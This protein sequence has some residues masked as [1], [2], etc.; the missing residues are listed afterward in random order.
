MDVKMENKK[1]GKCPCCE[2]YSIGFGE[3][4]L[5]DICPV[6]FWENGGDGPNHMTLEEARKNFN[7]IGAIDKKA[8]EFI[9]P[10]SKNKY[11]RKMLNKIKVFSF[12]FKYFSEKLPEC[13]LRIDLR[14]KIQN[15]QDHLP[16]GVTGRDA[17]VIKTI[18]KSEQ[19]KKYISSLMKRIQKKINETDLEVFIIAV[20]CRSGIHRSVVVADYISES[21]KKEGYEITT[22]HINL[23]IR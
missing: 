2:Y 22:E 20:G 8:L 5:W 17:I 6:C 19:N 23:K 13:N 1:M 18:F 10:E 11:K 3:E 9:N 14:N 12:G 7:Q 15:P 4:G 21:L 16:K